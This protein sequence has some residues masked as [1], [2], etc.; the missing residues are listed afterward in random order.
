MRV[1]LCIIHAYTG[2]QL[3]P[4]PPTYKIEPDLFGPFLFGGD[5]AH[6][7]LC[8]RGEFEPAEHYFL[9]REN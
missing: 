1:D 7:L 8:V 6:K 2:V 9:S 5:G 3:P 4:S